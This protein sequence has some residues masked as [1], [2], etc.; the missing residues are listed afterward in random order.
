MSSL[1][2]IR[3]NEGNTPYDLAKSEELKN[4]LRP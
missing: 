4:L 2:C 1:Q 3:D